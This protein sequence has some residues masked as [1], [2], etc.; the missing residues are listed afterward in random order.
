MTSTGGCGIVVQN[1]NWL[2]IFKILKG[3]HFELLL[4]VNLINS[5][6]L[7][8][9]PF[10][11]HHNFVYFTILVQFDQAPFWDLYAL[12]TR[13]KFHSCNSPESQINFPSHLSYGSMI[14]ASMNISL[15]LVASWVGNKMLSKEIRGLTN[16]QADVNL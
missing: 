3:A 5:H 16:R 1:Q 14:Q 11:M 13:L 15:Q 7:F 2:C 12:R 6:G 8:F 10:S 4:L 9:F